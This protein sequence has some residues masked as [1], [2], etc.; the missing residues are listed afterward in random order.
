MALLGN[1][2][3]MLWKRFPVQG[4][5]FYLRLYDVIALDGM[6]QCTGLQ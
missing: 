1:A 3:A 4:V 2:V 5:R 6:V